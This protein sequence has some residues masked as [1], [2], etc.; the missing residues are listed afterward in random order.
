MGQEVANNRFRHWPDL[1]RFYGLSFDDIR[2]MPAPIRRIYEREMARLI[3]E[4]QARMLDVMNFSHMKPAA[5]R[6]FIRR[7]NRRLQSRDHADRPKTEQ[8]L[9]E[10]AAQIGIAVKK[11]PMKKK[12]DAT[13]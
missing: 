7:L 3:A 10:H 13:G 5:Q 11:V 4:E 8:E 2:R 1:S 6:R 9:K 12:A